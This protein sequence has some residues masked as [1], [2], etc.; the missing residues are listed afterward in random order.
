MAKRKR[1]GSLKIKAKAIGWEKGRL[2]GRSKPGVGEK[3]RRKR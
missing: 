1:K 3:W 2:K